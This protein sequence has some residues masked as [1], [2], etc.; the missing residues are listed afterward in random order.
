MALTVSSSD[1]PF[2]PCGHSI[3]QGQVLSSWWGPV[4]CQEPFCEWCVAWPHSRTLRV[5]V[6]LSHWNYQRPHSKIFLCHSIC[7]GL[8][9]ITGPGAESLL[10]NPGP[11]ADPF[12]LWVL[13][14]VGMLCFIQ[15]RLM[16]V[17]PRAEHAASSTRSP[18]SV[19]FLRGGRWRAQLLV[20]YFE[21]VF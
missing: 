5:L 18:C 1:E 11:A 7:H 10:P 16:A 15:Q 14:Q 20:L 3:A 6:Q 2:W 13:C 9:Q 21:E 12:L 4:T 8:C 17:F 19:F